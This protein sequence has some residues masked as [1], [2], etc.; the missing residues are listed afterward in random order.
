[1][2]GAS[3]LSVKDLVSSYEMLTSPEHMGE[4]FQFFSITSSPKHAPMPF[5]D[6][7]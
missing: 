4:R 1:M 3:P 6:E 2:K 5:L 7:S